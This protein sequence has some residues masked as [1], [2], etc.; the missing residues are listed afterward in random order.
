MKR[1]QIDDSVFL[2]L[3][4]SARLVIYPGDG[5]ITSI[6]SS[7]LTTTMVTL[8]ESASMEVSGSVSMGEGLFVAI[9]I[10]SSGYLIVGLGGIFAVP[11]PFSVP[12]SWGR[13]IEV[14]SSNFA[15][16]ESSYWEI[17]GNFDLDKG[18]SFTT[19]MQSNLT[20]SSKGVISNRGGDLTLAGFSSVAVDGSCQNSGRETPHEPGRPMLSPDFL[21]DAG[22]LRVQPA[23]PPPR[24]HHQPRPGHLP[25]RGVGQALRPRRGS[26]PPS[27]WGVAG[28]RGRA[29]GRRSWRAARRSRS[30]RALRSRRTGP[31][32]WRTGA[33][34]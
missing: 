33:G 5:G 25:L 31:L 17:D 30:G 6:T 8:R 9:S 3:K 29:L 16:G 2:T 11:P 28:R 26:Q 24:E 34:S 1:L 12:G 14:E 23:G 4:E 32:R 15:V 27:I 7:D 13:R 21:R 19:G 10:K 18:S 20:I 22:D